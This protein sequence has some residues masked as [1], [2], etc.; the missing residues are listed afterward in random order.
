MI[1]FKTYRSS[2]IIQ[3]PSQII[4]FYDLPELLW[5]VSSIRNN[6]VSTN[7]KT[8]KK[9]G[10]NITSH[11]TRI[12]K[13]WQQQ[14]L[15]ILIFTKIILH[16][17]FLTVIHLFSICL[18]KVLE[19]LKVIHSNENEEQ[20][21]YGINFSLRFYTCVCYFILRNII[22]IMPLFDN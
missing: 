18:E 12:F 10:Q 22:K 3:T 9:D 21:D 11:S 17:I 16:V 20:K 2:V 8:L 14:S 4:Q 5:S 1:V 7:F 19:V 15:L 13:L 6:C